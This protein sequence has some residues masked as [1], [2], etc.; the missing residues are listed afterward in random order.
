M[1]EQEQQQTNNG[2]SET[3]TTIDIANAFLNAPSTKDKI[4]FVAVPNRLARRGIVEAGTAWEVRRA[5]YGFIE[6]R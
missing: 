5:V 1:K 2:R 4:M 3:L 6:S